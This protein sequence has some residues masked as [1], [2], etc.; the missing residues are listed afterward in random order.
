MH[1][2]AFL[3]FTGFSAKLP[4]VESRNNLFF[5]FMALGKV[6]QAWFRSGKKEEEEGRKERKRKRRR[7]EVAGRAVE[8][9]PGRKCSE[10]ARLEGRGGRRESGHRGKQLMA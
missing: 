6:Q 2:V 8:N 9:A 10:V 5:L 4:I 7:K 1:V 3:H